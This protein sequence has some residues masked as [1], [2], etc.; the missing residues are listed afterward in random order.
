MQGKLYMNNILHVERYMVKRQRDN[1]RKVKK[2]SLIMLGFTVK[3]KATNFK[4]LEKRSISSNYVKSLY[5][6][7]KSGF[8]WGINKDRFK[9][10]C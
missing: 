8:S 1:Y 7:V 4:R 9:I 2:R 5:K 3:L 6:R 10:F